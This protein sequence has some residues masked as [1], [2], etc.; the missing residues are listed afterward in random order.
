MEPKSGV[1]ERCVPLAKEWNKEKIF[2]KLT[3]SRWEI[4]GTKPLLE[5]IRKLGVAFSLQSFTNSSNRNCPSSH[6]N[7]CK[8]K[9]SLNEVNK[10]RVVTLD[11]KKETYESMTLI[12]SIDQVEVSSGV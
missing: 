8:R 1:Y 4:L 7:C 2:S 5:I 3:N 9:S 12:C 10:K 6:I 11:D